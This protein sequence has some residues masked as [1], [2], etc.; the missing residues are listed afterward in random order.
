MHSTLDE[1]NLLRGPPYR[2]HPH[3]PPR[4]PSCIS[5]N[6][7]SVLKCDGCSA[8]PLHHLPYRRSL[9]FIV[10]LFGTRHLYSGNRLGLV[11][12]YAPSVQRDHEEVIYNKFIGLETLVSTLRTGIQ[13]FPKR[14]PGLLVL[15]RHTMHPSTSLRSR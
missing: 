5:V 3:V 12:K 10:F 13:G 4:R 11:V 2:L 14:G 8:M 1:T 6:L 7:R 9:P 15:A